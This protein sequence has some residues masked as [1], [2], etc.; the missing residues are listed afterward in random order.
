[1][2]QTHWTLAQTLQSRGLSPHALAKVSG[3]SKNTVYDIVNGKSQGVT[4]ETVDRLLSGLEQLT[5][6]RMALEAVLDRQEPEDP[7][8]HLFADAKPFDWDQV[9]ST[10]PL[11]TPEEQAANDAFW[12]EHETERQSRR[13][14]GN[15]R[16]GAL[17]EIFGREDDLT[18]ERPS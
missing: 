13:A 11:W 14:T 8:L 3:L 7:Y 5:G 9:R 2:R 6:Q 1:M 10:L 4:L 18:Q 17:A 12:A 15:R 16:L